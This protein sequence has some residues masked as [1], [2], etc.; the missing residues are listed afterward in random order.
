M[1]P[2]GIG[3]TDEVEQPHLRPW[4]TVLKAPTTRGPVW[5][6]AAGPGTAFEVGL[7]EILQR[8]APNHVLT[9]IATDVTQGCIVLPD[10]ALSL[11]ERLPKVPCA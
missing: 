4:A 1:W 6:K 10:S 2:A 11:R 5:L 7:Y 3:R 8:D 9:P